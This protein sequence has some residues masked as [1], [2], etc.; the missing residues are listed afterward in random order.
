MDKDSDSS[1]CWPPSFPSLADIGSVE[2]GLQESDTTSDRTSSPGVWPSSCKFGP[3]DASIDRLGSVTE[4]TF[5]ILCREEGEECCE[6]NKTLLGD[7]RT[8]L[9]CFRTDRGRGPLAPDL[10][11]CFVALL[12]GKAGLF[13]VNVGN[14]GSL[15][16]SGSGDSDFCLRCNDK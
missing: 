15:G 12:P 1:L 11:G 2:S 9:L 16:T 8:E 14:S 13:G 6:G 5:F 3:P 4:K 7:S 10:G